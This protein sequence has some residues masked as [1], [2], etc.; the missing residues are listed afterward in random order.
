MQWLWLMWKVQA[1]KKRLQNAKRNHAR[2]KQSKD[3][4]H[5]LLKVLVHFM[6]Q[7]KI[8]LGSLHFLN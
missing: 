7:E 6:Q 1:K 3:L 5:M 4:V 2:E 8:T